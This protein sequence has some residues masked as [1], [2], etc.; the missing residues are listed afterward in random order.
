MQAFSCGI[1]TIMHGSIC[2][3]LKT[4]LVA[5]W[6]A[7]FSPNGEF[8]VY[9][10]ENKINIFQCNENKWTPFQTLTTKPA[11]ISTLSFSA[12]GTTLNFGSHKE[13]EYFWDF[14]TSISIIKFL[15]T[16]DLKQMLLIK[17]ISEEHEK[18]RLLNLTNEL[19]I[20]FESLS[21][22]IQSLLATYVR[23]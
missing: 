10:A 6:A 14:S 21:E 11:S 17:I 4:R 8:F 20:I 23:K 12:D 1:I 7:A 16:A 19:Q 9:S 13:V 2:V 5:F 3:Q 15:D 18:G 22:E